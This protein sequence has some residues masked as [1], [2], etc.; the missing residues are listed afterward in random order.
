MLGWLIN[1][2]FGGSEVP[3]APSFA[4]TG[5]FRIDMAPERR[6]MQFAHEDRKI[7]IPG[8]N[9]GIEIG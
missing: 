7:I 4:I 6:D 3:V 8:E 9:R 2:G 1:L 5:R